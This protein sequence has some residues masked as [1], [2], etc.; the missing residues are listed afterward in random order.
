MGHWLTA[1]FSTYGLAVILVGVYLEGSGLPLPGETVLLAG[2]FFARQGALPLG[3]VLA[4]GFLAAVAGDNTGY[5]IRRRGGRAPLLPPRRRGG[6]PPP[7][8]PPTPPL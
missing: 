4:C 3:W 1:A 2:G 5:W 6:L 8:P 7:P